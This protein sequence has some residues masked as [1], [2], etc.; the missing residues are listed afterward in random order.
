[1]QAFPGRG[2]FMEAKCDWTDYYENKIGVIGTEVGMKLSQWLKTDVYKLLC[3][4]K[5]AQLTALI[6]ELSPLFPELTFVKSGETHLEIIARGVD[7]ASGLKDISECTGI[8]AADMMA[9]G[10]EMNDLPM[11]KYAGT[12]I[13]MENAVQGVLKEIHRLA[14]KNTA[15]GVAKIV[16]QYLDEGRMGGC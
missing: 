11:L 7:K 3:L 13:A 4:G 2:Y 1:V 8:P 14:P 5:P 9:F 15:C 12:G 16:N 10:D 6:D